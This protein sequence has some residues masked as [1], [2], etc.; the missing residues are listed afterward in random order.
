MRGW[1]GVLDTEKDEDWWLWTRSMESV[2]ER[3][4]A[5]R[6]RIG[7]DAARVAGNAE[8]REDAGSGNSEFQAS[9]LRSL[10]EAAIAAKAVELDLRGP[11]RWGDPG[12][13]R[14]AV[15]ASGSWPPAE[16]RVFFLA[17]SRVAA[18]LKSSIFVLL[19]ERI[20]AVVQ[21]CS[22]GDEG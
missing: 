22:A 1:E 9:A 5:W 8:E 16:H 20:P 12:N 6:A 11:F 10:A 7:A 21:V 3:L 2:R 15:Y 14:V 19:D 18:G 17:S 4:I 13:P